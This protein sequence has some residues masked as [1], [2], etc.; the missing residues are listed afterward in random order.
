MSGC[1]KFP[2]NGAGSST[3]R[4]I[5]TMTMAQ[6]INTNYV[7]LVAIHASTDVNPTTQ[8]PIP[9]ISQPWGNG[10]V[11]GTV[12]L[13]VRWDPLTSPNYQIYRFQ[14]TNLTQYIPVGA[15]I[16]STPV[17]SGSN[18]I[19][20]QLDINQIA[21]SVAQAPLLQS[22]Q[23]NFLTMDRVPQGSDPG[24]KTYDALGKT[25]DLTQIND[26]VVIPLNRAAIYNNS[27]FNNLEPAS[28]TPDP[29]LDITN[30]QVEVRTQ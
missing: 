4:V 21:S 22:L 16:S 17:N 15:P 2:A 3:K 23:V 27:N 9:I 30:W 10:F 19:S 24:S 7:Y 29:A 6:P 8:G 11:A 1:A 13:F 25:D 20:F 5:F 26:F 12:D 14:D 18:T 28:D